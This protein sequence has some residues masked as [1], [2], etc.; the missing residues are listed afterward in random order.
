VVL[1]VERVTRAL[2]ALDVADADAGR[3]SSLF[4]YWVSDEPPAR[5]KSTRFT[6][7]APR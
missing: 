6:L 3:S 2:Y 1:G 5:R 7:G 4:S